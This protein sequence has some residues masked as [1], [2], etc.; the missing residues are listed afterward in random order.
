MR[1]Y[2]QIRDEYTVPI[3]QAIAN[4]EREEEKARRQLLARQAEREQVEKERIAHTATYRGLDAPQTAL[5]AEIADLE[6]QIDDLQRQATARQGQLRGLQA[7]AETAREEVTRH[8]TAVAAA[9]KDIARA[10]E[11]LTAQTKSVEAARGR[12]RDAVLQALRLYVDETFEFMAAY[13][14]QVSAREKHERV[15]GLFEAARHTDQSVLEMHEQRIELARLLATSQVPAIRDAL[16]KQ[17]RLVESALDERFPG[18]LQPI[19]PAE[20]QEP[21]ETFYWYD[22][23]DDVTYL[24][25]P[26]PASCWHTPPEV[27]EDPRGKRLAQLLWGFVQ[28]LGDP[29]PSVELVKDLVVLELLGDHT[30]RLADKIVEITVAPGRIAG[31]LPG[32][33]P[34]DLLEALV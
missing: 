27:R 16:N 24:L 29:V 31:F 32:P 23:E 10:G 21:I 1:T 33:A 4:E 12:Y 25:V 9:E 17:L 3:L 30:L 2:Q 7:Q 13:S 11:A 5:K 20:D 34:S 18:L 15:R 19:P 26:V 8:R 14:A 6:R 28:A 22:R